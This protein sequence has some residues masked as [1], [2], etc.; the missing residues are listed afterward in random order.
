MGKT[1]HRSADPRN[2]GVYSAYESDAS[3]AFDVTVGVAVLQGDALS[4][5]AGDYLVFQAQGPVPMSVLGAWKRIWHYFEAHPEIQRRYG[6]DLE[7]YSSPT[8]AAV[9]IGV[10]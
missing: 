8:E 1:V 5:E 3:G 4:V 9:Y 10:V 2:F 7:T 6:T